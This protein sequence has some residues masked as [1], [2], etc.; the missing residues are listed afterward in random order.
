MKNIFLVMFLSYIGFVGYAQNKPTIAVLP[1]TGGSVEDGETIAELFSFDSTINSV[2]SP[3]P[4]TSINSAIRRE[5]SFQMSGGMTD[6]DTISRIG[7]QLGA[8]YI[9]AGTIT[10]LGSQRLLIISIMRIDNLQQIAGDW[11]SYNDIG[12]IQDKL[13][14]MARDIIAAS[15][16]DTSRLPR[17]AVLPFQTPRGDREADALS[18]ILA[19]E[20]VRSGTYAVYP[21]TK[22]LE[23]I[24]QEYRNQLNGDTA[25]NQAIAIGRGDNPLLA[26]SG[27]VR[28]LGAKRRMFNAAI[29]NVESGV[30]TKGDYVNFDAIEEGL[31]SMRLLGGKL[32]G[33][34]LSIITTTEQF[35]EIINYINL[36]GVGDYTITIGGNFVVDWQVR[37]AANARKTITITGDNTERTIRNIRL[38]VPKDITLILRNNLRLDGNG[39]NSRV[40]T[41]DESGI[42][43]IDSGITVTGSAGGGIIVGKYAR[44]DMSGG[45][46]NNNTL[47]YQTGLSY[48]AGAGVFVDES[49]TFTMNGGTISNNI[50]TG[51]NYGYGGGVFLGDRTTFRMN[52]GVISGNMAIYGGGVGYNGDRAVFIKTGGTISNNS[53]ERGPQVYGQN[54]IIRCIRNNNA[55]PSV[56]LDNHIKGKAGG[57]DN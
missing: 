9:V 13:P 57:W 52:G 11:R 56:N 19:V 23:Q 3:I 4:R 28:G 22:T 29:I 6:P 39:I 18:Q 2:F 49:G 25:D 20:I 47:N 8:R 41:V 5:Q 42:L 31:I 46:I 44:F 51:G 45:N 27:A 54:N 32:T 15:K 34:D 53:A 50:Y 40:I 37:F 1:F 55:G 24:Q 43:R 10:N 35:K 12:E 38:Y 48:G 36:Q 14:E 17:L 30:Q 33:V 7:H 26:L 16:K 21:R